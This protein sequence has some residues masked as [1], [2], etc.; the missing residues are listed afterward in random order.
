VHIIIIIIIIIIRKLLRGTV[1]T[2]RG[3]AF[4]RDLEGDDCDL[5]EDTVLTSADV[6]LALKSRRGNKVTRRA[7]GSR[8]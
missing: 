6:R 7:V 2:C 3:F 1:F 4:R 5:L 8:S